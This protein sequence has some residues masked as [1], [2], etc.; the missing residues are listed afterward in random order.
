M[1]WDGILA[2]PLPGCVTVD[3][4]LALSDPQS[5]H[6]SKGVMTVPP[7]QGCCCSPGRGEVSSVIMGD[8]GT[9]S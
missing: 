7:P 2:P 4:L 1:V 9:R 5:P 6:H 8:E 3:S